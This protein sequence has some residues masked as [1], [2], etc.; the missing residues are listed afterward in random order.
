[1]TCR[2]LVE[3]VT[4]YL[5]GALS[6]EDAAGFEDHLARC[7]WCS[8]YVEQMRVTIST[9]GQ[10]ELDSISG[11]AR[12]TLLAAFSDWSGGERPLREP[13]G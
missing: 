3:L 9:V 1:M 11:E 5:D 7:D 13:Q 6:P 4:D 2:E 8:R 10:I 12:A